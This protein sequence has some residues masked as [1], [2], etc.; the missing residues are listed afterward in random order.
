MHSTLARPPSLPRPFPPPPSSLC[1]YLPSSCLPSSFLLS[2]ML[3]SPLLSPSCPPLTFTLA[4][5][6]PSSPPSLPL[7][8]PPH[9]CCLS[10]SPSFSLLLSFIHSPLLHSRPP[11]SSFCPSPIL[12][13]LLSL[14]T[15]SSPTSQWSRPLGHPTAGGGR[16]EQR[17]VTVVVPPRD[18]DHK[19]GTR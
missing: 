14:P 7:T 4:F 12:L 10:Y 6:L 17:V 2:L 13:S 18:D 19:L 8:F 5:P 15:P 9:P 3:S 11:S 1:S 16:A